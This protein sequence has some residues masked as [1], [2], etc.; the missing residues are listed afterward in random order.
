YTARAYAL[1]RWYRTP[2]LRG[3]GDQR[4]LLERIAAAAARAVAL[5]PGDAG[6]WDA[7]GNA[8]V[9]R[10]SYEAYHGGDGAPWWR[11]ALDDIGRALAIRPGDPW[12]HNDLAVAH[13]WL[14][15]ALA[16]RG[17][18]PMP[19]YEAALRGYERATEIDP[20]YLYAWFNQVDLAAVIAA[21]D[22][23]RGV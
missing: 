8:R 14:G 10:G 13:R 21:R 5:D 18:D 15:T 19:E 20:D 11:G 16:D 4:P 9:Y 2:A 22:A 17:G 23:D 3:A 1:L 12:G 7:L 6:A